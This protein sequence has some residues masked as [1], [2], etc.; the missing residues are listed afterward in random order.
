MNLNRSIPFLFGMAVATIPATV[1]TIPAIAKSSAVTAATRTY[2]GTSVHMTYGRVQVGIKVSGSRMTL[3]WA[4]APVDTA[5]SKQINT[6]AVPI[7]GREALS[8][9]SV[10]GIHKVSGASLTSFAFESSL[11]N[12]MAKAQLAGA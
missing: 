7:L 5:H 12:A 6:H 4:N 2:Y 8:A 9:Q 11:A 3:V 10:R 1:A